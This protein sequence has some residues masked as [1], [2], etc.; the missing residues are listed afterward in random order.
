MGAILAIVAYE[1][2][3]TNVQEHQDDANSSPEGESKTPEMNTDLIL[4]TC[5]VGI[6]IEVE[7]ETET[8]SGSTLPNE[9]IGLENYSI[10]LID[11]VK[12]T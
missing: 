12:T 9:F 2:H 4:W 11:R 7:P 10:R 6:L 1:L 3:T 5:P 8:N